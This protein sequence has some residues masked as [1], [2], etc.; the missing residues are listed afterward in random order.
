MFLIHPTIGR[1]MPSFPLSRH[2]MFDHC[3]SDDLLSSPS[4]LS[5]R[6]LARIDTLVLFFLSEKSKEYLS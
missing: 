2:R 1:W 4:G 5:H 6:F 3:A